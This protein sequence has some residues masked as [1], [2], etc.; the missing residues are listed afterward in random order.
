MAA[1]M[2]AALLLPVVITR[3]ESGGLTRVGVGVVLAGCGLI[4]CGMTAVLAGF[5]QRRASGMPSGVRA[6]VAAN[7][8]VLAFFTLESSDGLVRQHGRILY[9]ST[10]LFLPALLLF[11]GLL[12][13]RKWAWWISRGATALAALWFLGFVAVIPFADLQAN[14]VPVPWHGRVYMV[15][16]SLVFAGILAGAFW[17]LGRP[18][19]RIYFGLIRTEGSAAT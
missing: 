7:V 18:E 15:C 4:A 2:G 8:L 10:F 5:R 19:S 12:A 11:C 6:A 13:V 3:L 16:V 9:W 17:S 14:G 1:L